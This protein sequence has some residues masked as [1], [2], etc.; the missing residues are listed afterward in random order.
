LAHRVSQECGNS[1]E[2]L[3][4][5]SFQAFCPVLRFKLQNNVSYTSAQPLAIVTYTYPQKYGNSREVDFTL[6]GDPVRCFSVRHCYRE[7][8]LLIVDVFNNLAPFQIWNEQGE[9]MKA[10][11][12]S[13]SLSD[14]LQKNFEEEHPHSMP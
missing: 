11:E 13:Y 3:S 4:S 10:E 6:Q 2:T 5:S 7:D 9:M 14:W 8:F 1:D 12:L